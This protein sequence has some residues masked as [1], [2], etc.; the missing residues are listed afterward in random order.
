MNENLERRLK[1]GLDGDLPPAPAGTRAWLDRLP[2]DHPRVRQGRTVRRAMATA[3][4]VAVLAVGLVALVSMGG[5]LGETAADP[6][7]PLVSASLP[8]SPSGPAS[9]IAS[10]S[11]SLD[12]V[13]ATVHTVSELLDLRARGVIGGEPVALRGFWTD[14]TTFHSCTAPDSPPGELQ[15]R[16]HDGESGITEQDAPIATWINPSQYTFHDGPKL[17]PFVS[18]A[19]AQRLFTLPSINGQPYPPV[20]IVVIGHFD[21]PRAADCQPEARQ[22]CRDRLVIDRIVEFEPGAVPTPGVTPS[23]SPFPFDDPPA[24]P[25][26]TEQCAGDIAY[27]FIGWG[28]LADHGSDIDPGRVQFMMVFEDA[29]TGATRICF[30]NEWEEGS[31]TTVTVP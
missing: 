23:P 7:D 3:A 18:E 6:S 21:D 26:T 20:P 15:I 10:P 29:D 1:A 14:R 27:S 8:G 30:A 5:L 25:F 22:L 24:A 31:V 17:T 11:P 12:S 4:A 16:C 13:I 9:P 19:L 2:L 28:Y